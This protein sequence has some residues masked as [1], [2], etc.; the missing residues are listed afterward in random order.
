MS[1]YPTSSADLRNVLPT[2]FRS[3][4]RSCAFSSQSFPFETAIKTGDYVLQVHPW[5]QLCR[6]SVIVFPQILSTW[7]INSSQN[8]HMTPSTSEDGAQYTA[9][10]PSA[11]RCITKICWGSSSENRVKDSDVDPGAW[12]EMHEAERLK[13]KSSALQLNEKLFKDQAGIRKSGMENSYAWG[14]SCKFIGW[15]Q[16]GF[17]ARRAHVWKGTVP[18]VPGTPLAA[19]IRELLLIYSFEKP[20][21]SPLIKLCREVNSHAGGRR[22]KKRGLQFS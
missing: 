12:E 7:R 8:R 16:G 11:R 15:A 17:R 4:S 3:D 14:L 20:M 22:V 5:H 1:H 10:K 6:F 21:S 9:W 19:S 18:E 13:E 2:H